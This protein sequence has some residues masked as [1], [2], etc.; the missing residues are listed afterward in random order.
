M[1]AVHL[2]VIVGVDIRNVNIVCNL[3]WTKMVLL[4]T[5]SHSHN[6]YYVAIIGN[7]N[8][9]CSCSGKTCGFTYCTCTGD[10]NELG[11]YTHVRRRGE[12]TNLA[13]IVYIAM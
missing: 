1:Q 2:Y 12:H 7:H 4:I 9:V 6:N 3:N 13:C 11:V 10:S 8:F 5:V